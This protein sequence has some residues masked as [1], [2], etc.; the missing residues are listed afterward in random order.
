M[1]KILSLIILS[2][3][4]LVSYQN[5]AVYESE[6]REQ[7]DS[8]FGG[9][10]ENC[11]PHLDINI[12]AHVLGHDQISLTPI[13]NGCI[14][15][16]RANNGVDRVQYKCTF[17]QNIKQQKVDPLT[18]PTIGYLALYDSY[19]PGVASGSSSFACEDPNATTTQGSCDAP[20][21]SNARH[22]LASHL[23]ASGSNS[24]ASNTA[25][26]AFF[27][28]SVNGYAYAEYF[29]NEVQVR[30]LAA[31]SITGVECTTSIQRRADISNIDN[32]NARSTD[33]NIVWG[34]G[35]VNGDIHTLEQLTYHILQRL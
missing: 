24:F 33:Y 6:G 34:G 13:S 19:C 3:M 16:N 1:L 10:S 29:N 17:G 28:R 21:S 31:N 7:L 9:L 26:L 5:C 12:A 32:H 15:T 27:K 30:Y 14:I 11:L 4:V 8:I 35:G 2:A 23:I 18:L 20:T 25:L 22:C